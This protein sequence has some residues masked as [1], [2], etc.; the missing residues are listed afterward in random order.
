MRAAIY[1]LE[2]LLFHV[3]VVPVDDDLLLQDVVVELE[4][5]HDLD[6][7]ALLL[8][9]QG[10]ENLLGLAELGLRPGP[11]LRNVHDDERMQRRRDASGSTGRSHDLLKTVQY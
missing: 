6:V 1:L 9:D 5:V 4:R 7:A 3:V 2:L 10:S 8:A 11:V